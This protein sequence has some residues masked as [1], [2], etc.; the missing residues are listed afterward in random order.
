[1][2]FGFDLSDLPNLDLPIETY[3]KHL[4]WMYEDEM[5][6]K[7]IAKE[8]AQAIILE[9]HEER[10]NWDDSTDTYDRVLPE[11]KKMYLEGFVKMF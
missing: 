9:M 2:D 7:E 3:E 8:E 11:D 5:E 10:N 1:M 4:V 6:A